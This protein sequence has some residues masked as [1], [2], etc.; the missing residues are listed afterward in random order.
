MANIPNADKIVI[1]LGIESP[2]TVKQTVRANN[3]AAQEYA[4]KKGLAKLKSVIAL[5]STPNITAP[6]S[7]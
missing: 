4:I 6:V 5:Y 7:A 3:I 2:G 1:A